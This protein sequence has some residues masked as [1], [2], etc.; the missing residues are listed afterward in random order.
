MARLWLP[1]FISGSYLGSNYHCPA[2]ITTGFYLIKFIRNQTRKPQDPTIQKLET[3]L[4]QLKNK[5]KD[6]Q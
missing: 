6:R 3:E 4:E 5:Y 1:H 2:C